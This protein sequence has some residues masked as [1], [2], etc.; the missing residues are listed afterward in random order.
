M[1]ARAVLA[2]DRLPRSPLGR[3]VQAS[4]RQ[5]APSLFESG[6]E[7]TVAVP[8]T[9]F[10]RET[11]RARLTGEEAPPN[12]IA[13]LAPN[14]PSGLGVAA[15]HGPESASAPMLRIILTISDGVTP[16]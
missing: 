7:G 12:T 13:F 1:L 6:S 9:V 8:M 16:P 5:I 14:E 11:V 15:F 3:S 4:P 2:P 10:I